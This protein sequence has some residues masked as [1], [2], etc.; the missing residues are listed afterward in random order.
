MCANCIGRLAS[1]LPVTLL[2]ANT[3]LHAVIAIA[4]YA[5]WWHKPLS[6][7]YPISLDIRTLHKSSNQYRDPDSDAAVDFSEEIQDCANANNNCQPQQTLKSRGD[8]EECEHSGSY[9]EVNDYISRGFEI[10]QKWTTLQVFGRLT[11][12]PRTMVEDLQSESEACSGPFIG[13]KTFYKSKSLDSPNTKLHTC[14][15]DA[16]RIRS[17]STSSFNQ[18]EDKESISNIIASHY[19]ARANELPFR[20]IDLPEVYRSR[21]ME[22]AESVYCGRL[23][24]WPPECDWVDWPPG[25]HELEDGSTSDTYWMVPNPYMHTERIRQNYL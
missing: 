25:S 24:V 8:L 12:H 13:Y 7:E 19:Y 23:C 15:F 10:M 3:L 17:K 16:R 9:L 4:I 21:L 1:G 14:T 2:E 18:L 20:T 22:H 11:A 5:V 6:P